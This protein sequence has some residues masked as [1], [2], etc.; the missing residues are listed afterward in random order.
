MN[1]KMFSW[2]WWFM[3]VSLRPTWVVRL[4]QQNKTKQKLFA[5]IKLVDQIQD[6]S[7]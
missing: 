5:L 7:T 2:A 3:R 1:N 4:S 6:F